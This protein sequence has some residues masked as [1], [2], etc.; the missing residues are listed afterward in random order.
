MILPKKNF[1]AKIMYFYPVIWVKTKRIKQKRKKYI[2]KPMTYGLAVHRA[3]IK[4]WGR[5]PII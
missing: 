2:D 1:T 3:D 5:K 4:L